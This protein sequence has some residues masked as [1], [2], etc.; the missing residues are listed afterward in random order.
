MQ[1]NLKFDM[2]F[3][4]EKD[5]QLITTATFNKDKTR[6]CMYKVPNYSFLV[7]LPFFNQ[8]INPVIGSAAAIRLT[9][10]SVLF[11]YKLIVGYR[12]AKV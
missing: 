12:F 7:F 11:V 10:T 3:F 6:V 9:K 5:D 4:A 8:M 1:R 2:Q